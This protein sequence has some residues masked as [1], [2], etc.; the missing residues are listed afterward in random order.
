M[1]FCLSRWNNLRGQFQKEL[2]HSN[3]LCPKT[4][5]IRGSTWPYLE[6]LRFLECTVQAYKPKKEKLRKRKAKEICEEPQESEHV[7][8]S[9]D[10]DTKM[11][12]DMD[13]NDLMKDL[14]DDGQET[15]NPMEDSY[16]DSYAI[17]EEIA[18]EVVGTEE[19]IEIESSMDNYHKI[20]SLLMDFEGETRRRIERR[21]MAFLCKCQ[22]RSLSHQ[23]IEDLFV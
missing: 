6:R 17:I 19:H 1:Q 23:G 13:D 4:G 12:G 15:T 8:Q 14:E 2:K 10:S 20:Q 22:L 16:E 11:G 3:E 5:L 21:L 9:D 7:W 18:E